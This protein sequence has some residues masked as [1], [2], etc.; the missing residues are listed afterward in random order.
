MCVECN[1]AEWIYKSFQI[2]TRWKQVTCTIANTLDPG[3]IS[4]STNC[5]P[6]CWKWK[7]LNWHKRTSALCPLSASAEAGSCQKPCTAP[8]CPAF[9]TALSSSRHAVCVTY[10][11]SVW[12]PPL[13]KD[14]WRQEF[15][16]GP[17]TAAG[18]CPEQ[19]P[20][21]VATP[22]HLSNERVNDRT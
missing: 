18:Q 2:N 4:I 6:S 16:S 14:L 9:L 20:V 21:H 7:G 1:R 3:T 17:F 15:L 12:V 5:F 8:S 13:M 19:H 22:S 10:L 11:F